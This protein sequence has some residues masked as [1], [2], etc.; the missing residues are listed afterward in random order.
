MTLFM[1]KFSWEEK[2]KKTFLCSVGRRKKAG[3]AA[4][5]AATAAAAA[6]AAIRADKGSF[7]G[8]VGQQLVVFLLFYLVV[9]GVDLMVI[10]E[11]DC[12][13]MFF[14]VF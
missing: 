3:K 8:A 7:S 6:D 5:T 4:E 13:D 10:F 9:A 12:D 2:Q 11:F 1:K 14:V